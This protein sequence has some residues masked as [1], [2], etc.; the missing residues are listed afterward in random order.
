MFQGDSGG[1]LIATRADRYF[2]Q[3]IIS[4]GQTYCQNRTQSGVPFP[5]KKILN[6]SQLLMSTAADCFSEANSFRLFLSLIILQ[7]RN[8]HLEGVSFE[9][10]TTV[11]LVVGQPEKTGVEK[12]LVVASL[13]F[14]KGVLSIYGCAGE[15]RC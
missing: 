15:G 1:G 4:V 7:N 10:C 11:I 2:L 3:G 5:L 14:E 8:P 12:C 6:W 13:F 9:Q